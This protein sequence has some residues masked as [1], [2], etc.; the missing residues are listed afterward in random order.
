MSERKK[1]I[2]SAAKNQEVAK[3]KVEKLAYFESNYIVVSEQNARL[4]KPTRTIGK[5]RIISV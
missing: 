1:E 4:Y 2:E 5:K 3:Q